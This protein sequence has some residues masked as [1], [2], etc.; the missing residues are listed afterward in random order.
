MPTAVG[1]VSG[2]VG[3]NLS[4]DQTTLGIAADPGVVTIGV[5][6]TGTGSI[7]V[8][9][10][11]TITAKN[12]ISL[13]LTTEGT[14]D[15]FTPWGTVNA[16]VNYRLS[17]LQVNSPPSAGHTCGS[18]IL[19]GQLQNSFQWL[20]GSAFAVETLYRGGVNM[21]SDISDSLFGPVS[22][23]FVPG[24]ESGYTPSEIGVLANTNV[25]NWGFVFTAPA[26]P[27]SRT[28]RVYSSLHSVGVTLYVSSSDGSVVFT[29]VQRD[30]GLTND[31]DPS[32]SSGSKWTITY[33]SAQYGQSL[34]VKLLA[35]KNYQPTDN[36]W[37][38]L[39]AITLA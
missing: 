15:W 5:T 23:T 34:F 13:N 17:Q 2:G 24:S 21:T 8:A 10:S 3:I 14:R 30:S 28:L 6:P 31:A 27:F 11:G 19:G 4:G 26:D 9:F 12:T 20:Q 38:T 32:A 35:T 25:L 37:F 22:S 7:S 18:K 29:D 33:N 16:G 36:S 1:F 39:T